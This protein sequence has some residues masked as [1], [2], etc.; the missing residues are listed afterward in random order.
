M[1]KSQSSANEDMN[2]DIRC[3]AVDALRRVPWRPNG[4]FTDV[5]VVFCAQECDVD[6]PTM[7]LCVYIYNYVYKTVRCFLP[8][9]IWSDMGTYSR[10]HSAKAEAYSTASAFTMNLWSTRSLSMWTELV[11][12]QYCTVPLQEHSQIIE[13]TQ[14]WKKHGNNPT[15]TNKGTTVHHGLIW[16]GK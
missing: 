4:Q 11:W 13:T 1:P 8:I 6:Y 10:V 2:L 14:G 15:P 12:Y 9:R 3:A 16:V 5:C 7:W